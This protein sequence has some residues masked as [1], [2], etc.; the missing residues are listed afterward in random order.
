M[1]KTWVCYPCLLWIPPTHNPPPRHYL[2]AWTTWLTLQACSYGFEHKSL[3]S[4][5]IFE[6]WK[7]YT[8]CYINKMASHSWIKF[9]FTFWINL[10]VLLRQKNLPDVLHGQNNK[11]ENIKNILGNNNKQNNKIPVF[12]R[13]SLLCSH[14][15]CEYHED[16]LWLL[17]WG[18]VYCQR[19]HSVLRFPFLLPS[20]QILPG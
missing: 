10:N 13:P 14:V 11:A 17:L 20:V 8:H 3:A 12:L 15:P 1:P 9:Y 7:T 18:S 4:H 5:S 19:A 6:R 2:P 16:D